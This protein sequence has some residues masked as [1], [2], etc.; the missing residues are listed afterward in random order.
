MIYYEG[1]TF[2]YFEIYE[3]GVDGKYTVICGVQFIKENGKSEFEEDRHYEK[4]GFSWWYGTRV[5]NS[6]LS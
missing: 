3:S 4:V 1:S 5:Y 6:I 2:F